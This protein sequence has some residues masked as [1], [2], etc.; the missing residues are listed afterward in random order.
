M[1]RRR[2]SKS[3]PLEWVGARMDT[4]AG[5][6]EVREVIQLALDDD[7]VAEIRVIDSTI[8]MNNGIIDDFVI[9]GLMLSMDP[10]VST[11][12]TPDSEVQFEDLETFYTHLEQIRIEIGTITN[13]TYRDIYHK[14]LV[15]PDDHPL[16][17][18]TNIAALV[19]DDV[20]LVMDYFVRIYFT[21][22]KASDEDLVR[23][24]LKRR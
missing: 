15:F 16:L 5:G 6:G 11:A 13:L 2:S 22:R 20:A 7:E 21:R 12:A 23:T 24:L 1:A 17:V 8:Q 19:S 4:T 10:S 18:A 14:Q 3:K 9:A